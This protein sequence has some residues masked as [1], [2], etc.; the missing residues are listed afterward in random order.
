[1]YV[2]MYAHITMH[3]HTYHPGYL[4]AFAYRVVMVDQHPRAKVNI[5]PYTFH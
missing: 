1:M 3:T 2:C 4:F 5:N